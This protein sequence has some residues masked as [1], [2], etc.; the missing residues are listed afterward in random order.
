MRRILRTS[1]ILAAVAGATPA[2]ASSIDLVSGL[3]TNGSSVVQVTCAHCPALQPKISRNQYQVPSVA[4]GDQSAEVVDVNGQK[5]LKRVESWLGGSPVVFMTSAE[6]WATKGSVIVAS[7]PAPDGVDPSATT[8]AV[9]N[10][11]LPDGPVQIN[12]A[13]FEL[14]LK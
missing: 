14:R 12:Q 1:M 11:S 3:A 5:K 9:A 10:V 2:L 7:A 13:G 8:A 6:G 4:S